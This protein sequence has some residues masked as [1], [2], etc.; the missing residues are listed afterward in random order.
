VPTVIIHSQHLTTR[1]DWPGRLFERQVRLTL[2]VSAA[3]A[4]LVSRRRLQTP[5]RRSA[6]RAT[7]FSRVNAHGE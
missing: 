2:S 7:R 1:A 3:A 4:H 5:V 6:D